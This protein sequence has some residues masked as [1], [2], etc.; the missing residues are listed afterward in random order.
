MGHQ[1]C[2]SSW[3]CLCLS[4][5]YTRA[6]GTARALVW[7]SPGGSVYIHV[8][9]PGLALGSNCSSLSGLEGN[10]PLGAQQRG[11]YWT[12]R[13]GKRLWYRPGVEGLKQQYHIEQQC[14]S[15]PHKQ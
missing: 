11:T 13:A 4:S 9:A 6:G 3:L 15:R 5:W 8:V 7:V 10:L 12:R 1:D 2:C 14:P